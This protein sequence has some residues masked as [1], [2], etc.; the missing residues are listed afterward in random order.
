MTA[1]DWISATALLLAILAAAGSAYTWYESRFRYS[2]VLSWSLES[3]RTLQRL[4]LLLKARAR[5]GQSPERSSSINDEDL[6]RCMDEV[7]VQIEIGRVFFRNSPGRGA[8]RGWGQDKPPA[9]RGIRPKLLDYLVGAYDIGVEWQAATPARRIELAEIAEEAERQFVSLVQCEV[10]RAKARSVE[11]R[12]SG[13]GSPLLW[14][15]EDV[16]IRRRL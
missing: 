1:G 7:S 9:Y 11:A 2:E 3:I 4:V 14:I 10:G 5:A 13:T 16:R 15:E 8:L 12:A 6:R